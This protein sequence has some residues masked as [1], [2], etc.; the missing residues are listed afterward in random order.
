[1]MKAV[2]VLIT[3]QKNQKKKKF[4]VNWRL[5]LNWKGHN[6]LLQSWLRK[7]SGA[8]VTFKFLFSAP[9]TA[10]HVE[11]VF[12]ANWIIIRCRSRAL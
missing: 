12:L 11:I 7:L 9:T 4:G 3:L 8:F 2:H 10:E 5:R 6:Y 1:M